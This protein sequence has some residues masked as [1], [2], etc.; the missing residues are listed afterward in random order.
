MRGAID[1]RLTL[2][3]LIGSAALAGGCSEVLAALPTH[4]DGFVVR[5]TDPR[6]CGSVAFVDEAAGSDPGGGTSGNDHVVIRD[7]CGDGHGVRA[8]AWLDGD[9]EGSMYDGNGSAGEPVVWEPFLGV[10]AGQRVELKVC[11]VDGANDTTASNCGTATQT[12]IDG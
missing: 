7:L 2:L 5:T 6:E 4:D 1:T 9:Y 3:T 8:Y 12:S 11:L 10:G